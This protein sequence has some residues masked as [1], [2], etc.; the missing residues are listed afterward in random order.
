MIGW[1]RVSLIIILSSMD[2]SVGLHEKHYYSLPGREEMGVEADRLLWTFLSSGAL[3]DGCI[4]SGGS[5]HSGLVV[6]Y[7]VSMTVLHLVE[8][9]AARG[10]KLF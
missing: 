9:D 1:C 2:A 8:A 6:D 4:K 5:Q 10:Q 3:D 7:S